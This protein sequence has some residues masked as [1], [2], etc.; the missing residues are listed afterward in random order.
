MNIYLNDT[1]IDNSINSISKSG[2]K[3]M[4]FCFIVLFIITYFCTRVGFSFQSFLY[5]H[6]ILPDLC[7]RDLLSDISFNL[8][9]LILST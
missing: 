1:H 7:I 8:N 3:V 6:R 4:V 2:G 5:I 9:I